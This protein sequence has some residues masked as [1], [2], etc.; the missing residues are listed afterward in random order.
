MDLYQLLHQQGLKLTVRNHLCMKLENKPQKLSTRK[1][2]GSYM[3]PTTKVF[4]SF[5]YECM[6]MYVL[7]LQLP[8]LEPESCPGFLLS[9]HPS[10]R[11]INL[12]LYIC[13]FLAINLA[14]SLFKWQ[15]ISYLM[16]FLSSSTFLQ[17]Q[18]LLFHSAAIDHALIS[19][20][21]HIIFLI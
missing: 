8:K 4:V 12:F 19:K 9:P 20:S 2:N 18:H 1:Q 11:Q 15:F 6:Y 5:F 3:N 10:C 17:V 13:P 14:F 21:V 7:H 16:F